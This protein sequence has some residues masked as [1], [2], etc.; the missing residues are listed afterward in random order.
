M[1]NHPDQVRTKK[2]HIKKKNWD[3][4]LKI[5]VYYKSRKS[6]RKNV[7][8]YGKELIKIHRIEK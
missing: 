1:Q 7:R 2:E 4:N 8:N 3:S 6:R 5:R